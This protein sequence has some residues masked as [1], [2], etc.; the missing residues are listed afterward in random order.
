MYFI[1]FCIFSIKD[2]TNKY[3]ANFCLLQLALI[4][5]REHLLKPHARVLISAILREIERER[6]GEILSTLRLRKIIECLVELGITSDQQSFS[7]STLTGTASSPSEP[8]PYLMKPFKSPNFPP[9]PSGSTL[10]PNK[11]EVVSTLS[12]CLHI[13]VQ[14]S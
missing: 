4:T 2:V 11:S 5:W 6:R 1:T 9:K 10:K 3:F 8:L 14:S 12:Y 13:N 7:T